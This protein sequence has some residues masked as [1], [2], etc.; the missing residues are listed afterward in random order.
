M[1]RDMKL[2]KDHTC[3]YLLFWDVNITQAN[4]IALPI[5]KQEKYGFII[6][7]NDHILW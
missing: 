1:V 6:K 3:K 2:N 4:K 5:Y 7:K